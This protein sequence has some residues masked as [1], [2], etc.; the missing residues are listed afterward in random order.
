MT[1]VAD[2]IQKSVLILAPRARVWRAL[3]SAEQF[4]QWFGVKLQGTFT[5]GAR[6][7]MTATQPGYEGISWAVIVERVEPER[8]FSWR[9]HPGAEQPAEGSEPMTLVEFRLE[10]APGGTRVT[11]TESGFDQ[12][13]LARRA[14]A[15]ADNTQ[16]WEEQMASLERYVRA[17]G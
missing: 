12:V 13:T 9:W 8:L 14:K 1:A 2:R 10:D 16:G 17:Q 6:V 4:A 7:P 5:A 15:Y 3:T 11:V